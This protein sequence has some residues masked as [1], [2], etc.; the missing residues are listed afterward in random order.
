MSK[1]EMNDNKTKQV[2]IHAQLDIVA[3]MEYALGLRDGPSIS[4]I[5]AAQRTLRELRNLTGDPV[6]RDLADGVLEIG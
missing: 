4:D 2:L 3:L 6:G 5:N 1:P